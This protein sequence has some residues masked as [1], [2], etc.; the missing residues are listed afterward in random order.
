VLGIE[1]TFGNEASGYA[2]FRAGSSEFSLFSRAEMAAVP[3]LSVGPAGDSDGFVL[4]LAVDDM[5]GLVSRLAGAGFPLLTQP[6][7]RPDW[8]IRTAHLRDPAGHL[9]EVFTPLATRF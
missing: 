3:G 9:V 4:V 6:E 7:D 2:D 5:D 1:V 8:G